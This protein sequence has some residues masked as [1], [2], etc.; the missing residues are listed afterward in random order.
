MRKGT[1]ELNNMSKLEQSYLKRA[2]NKLNEAKSQLQ[3][4]NYAESVSASQECIE[5]SVKAVFLVLGEQFP[6]QHEFKEQ[7]FKK[8]LSK[9]PKELQFY[10]FPRLYL[11]SKFWSEFYTVAKYG[12]EELEVGADKLFTDKEAKLASEHAEECYLAT[13]ALEIRIP[14]Q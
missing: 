8:L 5:L 3:K 4:Y 11:L 2:Y 13:N 7:N 6:K 12:L 9:I 1:R 14:K 10:N